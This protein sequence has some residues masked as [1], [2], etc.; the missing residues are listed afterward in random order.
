MGFTENGDI[1]KKKKKKGPIAGQNGH[2]RMGS[3]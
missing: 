3:K 1:E 2:E